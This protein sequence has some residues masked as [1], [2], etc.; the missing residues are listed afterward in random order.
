MLYCTTIVPVIPACS[1][2]LYGYSPAVEK[3]YEKLAPGATFPLA[4]TPSSETVLWITAP[5]FTQRTVVPAGTVRVAGVKELSDIDTAF[6]S[7][8]GGG[9]G[10]GAVPPEPSPPQPTSAATTAMVPSHVR[11]AIA[12]DDAFEELARSDDSSWS[13][14]TLRE[15]GSEKSRSDSTTNSA[16]PMRRTAQARFALPLGE[17]APRLV[18]P[19]LDFTGTESHFHVP[20]STI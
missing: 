8:G 11:S 1:V 16:K 4:Q 6:G 3:A 15:L 17:W 5:L 19:F 9:G 10:G 13:M 18:H 20:V 14:H 12:C 7:A 2:H